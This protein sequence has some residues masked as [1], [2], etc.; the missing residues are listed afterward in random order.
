VTLGSLAYHSIA[1]QQYQRADNRSNPAGG[2]MQV[3]LAASAGQKCTQ[4][5]SYERA[6]NAQQCGEHETHGLSTGHD[7]PGDETDND[8]ENDPTVESLSGALGLSGRQD[9]K[10]A[11][12]SLGE[13]FPTMVHPLGF[14]INVPLP[15][16]SLVKS[17]AESQAKRGD[18]FPGRR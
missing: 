5:A 16:R 18:E 6:G 13:T 17:T 8:A 1:E 3:G 4:P 15:G 11:D 12:A 2:L 10:L 14:P 7:G 9:F